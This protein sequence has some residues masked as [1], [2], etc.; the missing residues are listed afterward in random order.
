MYCKEASAASSDI[1]RPSDATGVES[2]IP[3]ST[4][5]TKTNSMRASSSYPSKEVGRAGKGVLTDIYEDLLEASSSLRPRKPLTMAG[6]S[7]PMK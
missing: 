1:V 7:V 3:C 5:E 6:G 4:S 2:I